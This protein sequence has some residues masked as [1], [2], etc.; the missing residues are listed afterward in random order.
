MKFKKGELQPLLEI[1]GLN[2]N[3]NFNNYS[4]DPFEFL[5]RWMTQNPLRD[6]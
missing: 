6:K 1:A 4:G 5:P 2:V 3:G